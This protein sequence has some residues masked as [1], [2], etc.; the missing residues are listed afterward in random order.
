M[1]GH[2]VLSTGEE[3]EGTLIGSPM[4][5]SGELV[6]TTGMVGYTET[7]TDP[8]YF[9]Q[10][11]VFAYPLIGNYGVIRPTPASAPPSPGFE[12]TRIHAAGVIVATASPDAFHWNSGRTLDEWLRA[13]G[14]PGLVGLDTR[15]LVHRMRE[16]SNLLGRIEPGR[17]EGERFHD[18][19]GFYDPN[20]RDLLPL[21]ST[22]VRERL[23]SGRRRAA[24]L[25]C[26]AKWNIAR[27]IL[28]HGWEVEL[29]PW[30]ADLT[31]IDC[32]AW[33]LSNGPG[34]PA[35]TGD[36]PNRLRALLAADRPILGICLGHQ[37]LARAAGARTERMPFGHR[38]HNQPVLEVGTRRGFVTAQ[39]HGYSVVAD[40]L[41][42]GWRPWFL[43]ANDGTVEGIRHESGRFRSVQFHPEAAGGPRDTEHIF[44][45]FLGE[46]D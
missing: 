1:R 37:L 3:L 6:F 8:S 42:A 21:V 27:R 4:R 10:L 43:N 23:G 14:V 28:A 33:V 19:S 5:S 30:D 32:D 46:H 13:E 34:D 44:A 17:A 20:R 22:P 25:D 9:G 18:A 45:D 29:V 26:G 41:P 15:A 39:N 12:S 40:S 11:L 38:S 16:T 35:R 7:L 2:L 36:L 31:S 24:L